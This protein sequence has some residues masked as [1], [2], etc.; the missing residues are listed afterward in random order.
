MDPNQ[1]QNPFDTPVNG[2]VPPQP[3]PQPVVQPQN[4]FDNPQQPV[5]AP[6]APM[7]TPPKKSK[8]GLIV[9][10]AVG[11]GLFIIGLIIVLILVLGGG[12]S[13]KDYSDAQIKASTVAT[14]YNSISSVYISS[15]STETEIKNGVDKINT[16]LAE[17]NSS[18][19]AL[20][21]TKAIK[22]DQEA[23]KLYKALTDKKT[24]FD[25]VMKSSIESYEKLLPA[26]VSIDS[27]Q[28]NYVERVK[29]MQKGLNSVSGLVSDLNIKFLSDLKAIANDMMPVAERVQAGLD[30]YTK[31][32]SSATTEF[33][34]LT[35]KWTTAVSDWQSNLEKASEGAE[36][37]DQ[38]NALGEYLTN[39][40]N[41]VK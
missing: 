15:Y 17:F 22:N 5:T 1:Q 33:Y 37:K 36:L 34:Q 2:T 8:T 41:G 19:T 4:P 29:S 40:V 3:N 32:D 30:D 20:G 26:F 14:E 38:I 6:A 31:Y 13:K 25:E 24:K 7:V 11:G 28:S 23:A 9:G 18:V 39:K 35:S 21:E 27:T 12:I 16:N 10:L